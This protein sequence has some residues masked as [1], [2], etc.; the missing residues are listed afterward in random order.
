MPESTHCQCCNLP[1]P[2]PTAALPGTPKF[3]E[4]LEKRALA[5]QCLRHPQDRKPGARDGFVGG[6]DSHGNP[7]REGGT[8]ERSGDRAP[9]SAIVQ[10]LRRRRKG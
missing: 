4:V 8:K 10:A 9:V 6:V 2:E 3:L 5:N 1:L 7:V